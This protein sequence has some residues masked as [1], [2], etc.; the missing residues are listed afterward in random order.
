MTV[1]CLLSIAQSSMDINVFLCV[2]GRIVG[3]VSLLARAR[4]IHEDIVGTEAYLRTGMITHKLITYLETPQLVTT[5]WLSL[6]AVPGSLVFF[7]PLGLASL[8]YVVESTPRGFTS[9]H[10]NL[11]KQ[12][13]QVRAEWTPEGGNKPWTFRHVTCLAGWRVYETDNVAPSENEKKGPGGLPT[14]ICPIANGKPT[15]LCK[16]SADKRFP[17][18]RVLI[19]YGWIPRLAIAIARPVGIDRHVASHSTHGVANLLVA[20]L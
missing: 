9:W 2:S 11:I 15:T 20:N 5:S 19:G 12:N 13:G 7:A 14:L 1:R 4:T 18:Y 8:G 16:H 3:V 10:V 6:V 17:G